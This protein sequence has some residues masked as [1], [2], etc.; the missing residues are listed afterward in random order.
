[1]FMFIATKL[2]EHLAIGYRQFLLP[3]YGSDSPTEVFTQQGKD[4]I[5]IS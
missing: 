3:G 1:M 4:W 2:A 5:D